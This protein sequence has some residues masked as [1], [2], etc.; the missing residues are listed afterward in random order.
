[1][2]LLSPRS[3]NLQRRF[4]EF[5]I[6]HIALATALMYTAQDMMGHVLELVLSLPTCQVLG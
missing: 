6:W 4:S 3:R 5:G 1:V 2:R